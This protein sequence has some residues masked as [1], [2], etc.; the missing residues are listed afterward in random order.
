MITL[1]LLL[2]LIFCVIALAFP[3]KK[4]DMWNAI[5]VTWIIILCII[6]IVFIFGIII[7]FAV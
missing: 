6:M 2:T 3:D 1:G 4:A 5:K 7:A